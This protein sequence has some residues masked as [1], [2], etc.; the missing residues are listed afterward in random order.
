MLLTL[1]QLLLS[2][3]SLLVYT[4]VVA[5]SIA[6]LDRDSLDDDDRYRKLVGYEHVLENS[7][8]RSWELHKFDGGRYYLVFPFSKQIEKPDF[9]C[10]LGGKPVKIVHLFEDELNGGV[11]F[12]GE[13]SC[14]GTNV[15]TLSSIHLF[16][17]LQSMLTEQETQA[18]DTKN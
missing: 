1:L 14:D 2:A 6:G 11:Y 5:M 3:C 10:A 8:E 4:P 16:E 9:V 7:E 15:V 18:I 17:S 13:V 12:D